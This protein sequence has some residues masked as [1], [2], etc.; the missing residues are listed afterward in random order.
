MRSISKQININKQGVQNVAKAAI[1]FNYNY[2][3]N[4]NSR[5]H[6]FRNFNHNRFVLYNSRCLYAYYTGPD[7]G[8]INYRFLLIYFNMDD[9][10]ILDYPLFTAFAT[11]IPYYFLLLARTRALILTNIR[12]FFRFIRKEAAARTILE[13]A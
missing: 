1:T 5:N 10:M 11:G 4:H 3:R 6:Y 13:K 12:Y 7:F 9:C 2:P 8:N